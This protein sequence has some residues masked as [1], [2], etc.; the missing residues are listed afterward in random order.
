MKTKKIISLLASSVLAATSVFGALSLTACNKS[1]PNTIR[2]VAY[3]GG[4]ALDDSYRI[5][6]KVDDYVYEKLG[7]HVDIEFVGYNNYAEKLGLYMDSSEDFDLCYSGS[8]LSG[9]T[10]SNRAANGYFADI[11]KDLPKYAPELYASMSE[12]IWDAAKV[13]GKIYGVI[14]EQIFARSVGVAIDKKIAEELG[15]TQEKVDAENLTYQDVIRTAMAHIKADPQISPDGVV[16]STTLVLGNVWDDII[17]QNYGLDALGMDSYYPGLIETDG[18]SAPVVFNQY[19][20]KYF[21][22]LLDFCREMH[23]AGYISKQQ[24]TVPITK[25]Q[26]VRLAG[27]YYPDV[28]ENELYTSIGREFVVLQFGPELLTTTNVTSS[29]TAIYAKSKK[30]DKCLKFLNLLYT[31]QYLYNLLAIGEEDLEYTWNTGYDEN[32]EEYQ[33]ISYV[34]TSKYKPYAD[35]ALGSQLN[36]YRKRG[37]SKDWVQTIK[38]INANGVVSPAYGFTYIP[39]Y[40]LKTNLDNC[41]R[42]ADTYITKFTNGTY[43]ASKTN[44]Q[45]IAEMNKEMKDY[46]GEIISTKQAQLDAF[47]A[48]K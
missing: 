42:I 10:Y 11:T 33:Y 13:N 4:G 47:L 37:Y 22:E 18:E 5:I 39:D 14:N 32:D 2:Y 6:K 29:M 24:A 34:Q 48:N 38:D 27:S 19:E 23:E 31:D 16:P 1:D 36:T 43:D 7:F 35:W 3:T 46:V 45:I 9:L 21:K 41:Y 40:K 8:L 15:L 44:E 20:S 28:A 12:Q 17:T 30:V 25:N 26:R